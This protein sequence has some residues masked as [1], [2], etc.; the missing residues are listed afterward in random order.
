MGNTSSH[1]MPAVESKFS[2]SVTN[3]TNLISECSQDIE[4]SSSASSNASNKIKIK[5]VTVSGKGAKANIDIEQSAEAEA[6]AAVDALI[7]NIISSNAD[8]ETKLDAL[9]NT[10]NFVNNSGT[11]FGGSA[12]NAD[13]TTIDIT[14]STNMEA[15]QKLNLTVRAIAEA[16][17]TNEIEIGN[18]KVTGD[19]A[20]ANIKIVQAANSRSEDIIDLV[21]ETTTGLTSKEKADITDDLTKTN[22]SASKGILAGVADNVADVAKTGINEAADVA[23]T[24]ISEAGNVAKMSVYAIPIIII[25]AIISL[26]CVLI[27]IFRNK[28][29]QNSYGGYYKYKFM[30]L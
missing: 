14:N 25:I 15:I 6:I 27:Y 3:I 21:N 22:E 1:D 10:A 4:L 5:D 12:S 19:N 30:K 18:V 9:L 13:I 16:V 20:E 26:A 8:A 17:A 7:Q 23:K 29:K 2:Q 24:G 11:T 28:S